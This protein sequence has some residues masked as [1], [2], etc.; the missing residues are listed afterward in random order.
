MIL[1]SKWHIHVFCVLHFAKFSVPLKPPVPQ[2]YA[3]LPRL[4]IAG[5]CWGK[6][7]LITE[8]ASVSAQKTPFKGSLFV[9]TFSY[10][11][12]TAYYT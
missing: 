2:P 10:L 9:A 12:A 6:H 7:S 4:D 8:S 1:S 3:K 5:A 11:P